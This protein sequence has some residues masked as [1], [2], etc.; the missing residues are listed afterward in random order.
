MSDL[1]HNIPIFERGLISH[2]GA[3]SRRLGIAPA[4]PKFYR[5]PP[6]PVVEQKRA[7]P[8]PESA[9][10]PVLAIIE[11]RRCYA[12][13]PVGARIRLAAD[14]ARRRM[15]ARKTVSLL[16]QLPAAVAAA[17]DLSLA[18]VISGRR[19]QHIVFARHVGFALA[20]RMTRASLP[21]IGRAFKRDHTTVMHGRDR[22]A[23]TVNAAL[24]EIENT[25][26]P[27]AVS[28]E[29]FGGCNG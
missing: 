17:F 1:S 9:A 3:V 10:L 13:L 29:P 4:R 28:A 15:E 18:E 20:V 5:P 6:A 8:E 23:A 2:Y 27:V 22:L 26:P 19:L 14:I 21:A 16:S 24:A 11:P 25:E 12:G 7:E